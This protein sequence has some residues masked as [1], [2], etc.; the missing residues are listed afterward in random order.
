VKRPPAL[1]TGAIAHFGAQAAG[2][3]DIISVPGDPSTPADEADVM[4][5][6]H[7]GD[8]RAG[9]A[10]GPDYDPNPGAPDMALAFNLRISD[11]YNG[12][13]LDE[14]A[15]VTDVD[16]LAPISCDATSDPSLG[17]SCD[18]ATSADALTPGFV[19]E[20]RRT[21]LQVHR[22]RLRDSG[23]DGVLGNS[24]DKGSAMQGI[25]VP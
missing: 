5:S 15:T 19:G 13:A 2:S 4:I 23:P 18:A 1:T 3:A 14:P 17:A 6:A 16:L 12:A 20:G 10:S 22:V 24:D 21:V 7:A 8:I 11:T 25:Y 9:G